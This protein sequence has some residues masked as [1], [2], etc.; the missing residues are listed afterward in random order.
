LSR[1]KAI[2]EDILTDFYNVERS[3]DIQHRL[4]VHAER[5]K[6]LHLPEVPGC[7]AEADFKEEYGCA[8]VVENTEK[9]SV[10]ISPPV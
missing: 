4:E 1:I 9:E 6:L 3:A 2:Q 8:R 5:E 7:P 10:P